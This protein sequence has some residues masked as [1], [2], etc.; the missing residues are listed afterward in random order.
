MQYCP[1]G[2]LSYVI[3]YG[4]TLWI[5]AKRFNTTIDAIIIANPGINLENIYVGQS[6]C[7][8]VTSEVSKFKRQSYDRFNYTINLNN[9]IRT[10]WMEHV[11]WT[12]L[13]ILGIILEMPD[14]EFSTAKLLKNPSDLA[15]VFGSVYE[16]EKANRIKSLFYD[17]L[18]IAA[19]IVKAA[20]EGKNFQELERKWYDNA[21]EIA[22]F[23]NSI[24]PY[25]LE[26]EWR[27]MLHEHLQL[28]MQEAVYY[29]QKDYHN[30]VLI[31][32]RIEA[33][34][35]Q[36]ADMMTDGIIK[37]VSKKVR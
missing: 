22:K 24:N 5:L 17:H 1:F 11:V 15:E 7:I 27:V 26:L 36:M 19:E 12:R 13:V 32:D 14:L 3:Q 29:L 21:D 10:I 2:T 20:K 30:G 35:L 6:I 18:A 34:A 25:W 28:T 23:L 37:Q 33:Q 9:R 16:H 4:D 8:P 31:F